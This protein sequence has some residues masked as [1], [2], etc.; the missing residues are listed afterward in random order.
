MIISVLFRI[1]WN[2]SV[3]N[4]GTQEKSHAYLDLIIGCDMIAETWQTPVKQVQ[5]DPDL[6]QWSL[7]TL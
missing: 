6:V 5:K 3:K 7:R 4:F 2:S 1:S